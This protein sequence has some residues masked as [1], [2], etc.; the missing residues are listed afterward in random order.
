MPSTFSLI[1]F[2]F[3]G[4]G[5]LSYEATIALGLAACDA[6]K[7]ETQQLS[8]ADHFGHLIN[9]TFTGV[10]GSVEFDKLTGT[11][12]PKSSLYSV[13]N[14]VAEPAGSGEIEFKPHITDLFQKGEWVNQK[15]YIFNDGKI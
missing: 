2:L 10:S 15:P 3:S 6:Y 14:Y 4:F 7:E 1:L 9:T 5:P 12:D 11:R 13:A 8:G